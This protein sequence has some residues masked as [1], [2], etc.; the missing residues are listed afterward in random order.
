M[1]VPDIYAII[2]HDYAMPSCMI[3]PLSCMITTVTAAVC[4]NC[5]SGGTADSSWH[6]PSHERKGLQEIRNAPDETVLSTRRNIPECAWIANVFR[7]MFVCVV[8]V[9]GWAVGECKTCDRTMCA[10]SMF[11]QGW[12]VP[13]FHAWICTAMP[14]RKAWKKPHKPR[15]N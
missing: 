4:N 9:C 10:L 7:V 15:K 8:F 2:L 1:H 6:L 3:M 13:V 12:R 14:N 11:I 5:R